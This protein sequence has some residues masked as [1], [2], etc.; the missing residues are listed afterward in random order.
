V[1]RHCWHNLYHGG[2]RSLTR[3][4]ALVCYGWPAKHCSICDHPIESTFVMVGLRQPVTKGAGFRELG[5]VMVCELLD[6][7]EGWLMASQ[8][9]EPDRRGACGSFIDGNYRLKPKNVVELTPSCLDR[10]DGARL[11][12]RSQRG[13][14]SS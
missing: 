9:L 13:P 14:A 7:A 1:V 3:F 11:P 6:A 4:D 5:W 10:V 8:R 2:P 12:G